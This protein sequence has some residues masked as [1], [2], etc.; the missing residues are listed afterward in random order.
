VI[1]TLDARYYV[2]RLRHMG[3]R[4]GWPAVVQAS[5]A[6]YTALRTEDRAAVQDA[7]RAL[8]EALTLPL[9]VSAGTRA[10][11]T[12]VY[13]QLTALLG[14]APGGPPPREATEGLGN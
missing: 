4:Y 9:D 1:D 13:G 12:R 8:H 11:A 2:G 10:E 14:G 7:R 6:L 3:I 5:H